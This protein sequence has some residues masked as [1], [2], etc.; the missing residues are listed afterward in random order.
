MRQLLDVQHRCGMQ[1]IAE[2]LQVLS[3]MDDL[4]HMHGMCMPVRVHPARVAK[5]VL[6]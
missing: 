6:P 4:L 5:P 1:Q 2:L 3:I